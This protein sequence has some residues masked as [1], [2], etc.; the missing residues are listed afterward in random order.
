MKKETGSGSRYIFRIGAK[1]EPLVVLSIGAKHVLPWFRLT[2]I[3]PARDPKH[4]HLRKL[5]GLR[6]RGFFS[7]KH[8]FF[9]VNRVFVPVA[10]ALWKRVGIVLFCFTEQIA[11]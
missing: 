7:G 1:Q 2:W 3:T 8:G 9:P 6:A 5:G 11:I 4:G 10:E